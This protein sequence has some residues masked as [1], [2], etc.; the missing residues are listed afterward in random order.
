M[1][2]SKEFK[3]GL[4]VVTVLTVSFFLI[5]YLRGKDLFN[6]EI[7]ICARYSEVDGLVPSAP[8]FIKGYKAGKV[9][10]V[11]YDPSSDDFMVTCSVMKDFRIPVDSKMMIY[12]VDIMGGKGIRI[13][14]GTSQD[15]VAD[16]GLLSS[17][18]EP[19]MLDGLAAGVVPLMDKLGMT[20]DSIS[21]T[22]SSVNRLLADQNISRTIAH[23]EKTMSDVSD[24]VAVI[25]GKS[26]ELNV[27]LDNLASL[28]SQFISI[29]EKADTLVSDVSG[30]VSKISADELSAVVSSFRSLLENIND[31][32]GTVGR[33]LTDDSVYDSVDVLLNDVD[34]LI[35]KIQENPK[36][37]IKIS[38]F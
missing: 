11:I 8:V 29:S 1:T 7:E 19:A 9:T 22:V 21:V 10:E 33:L 12:G 20:L 6:K 16:G 5:N 2:F 3:I 13:D 23:L 28:S 27:F 30:L 31:P 38:V 17:S 18:S 4:F 36:K 35:R 14:L 24:I 25:D 32:D 26:D 37:Y 34:L 15:V